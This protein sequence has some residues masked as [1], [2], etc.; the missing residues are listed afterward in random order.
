MKCHSR[1]I[2]F[3]PIRICKSFRRMLKNTKKSLKW[4]F[5]KWGFEFPTTQGLVGAPTMEIDP[6]KPSHFFGNIFHRIKD[7][8]QH[9]ITSHNVLITSVVAA[10][11]V[12]HLALEKNACVRLV[13]GHLHI[14]Q[15]L[16]SFL[17]SSYPAAKPQW[18]KN[19]LV[20]SKRR[21][22]VNILYIYI[23]I[24][25]CEHILSILVYYI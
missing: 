16:V 1:A 6:R 15:W 20:A 12:G 21:L 22:S 9:V 14:D 11:H 5:V 13:G 19:H 2:E 4:G 23:Y 17:K 25:I 18:H 3:H 24:N 8:F 7:I 10:W